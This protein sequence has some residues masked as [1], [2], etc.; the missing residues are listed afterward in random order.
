MTANDELMVAA[1]AGGL[2]VEQVFTSDRQLI[3]DTL[4]RMEYDISL[5]NGNF[6]HLSEQPFFGA[7][8]VLFS[9]LGTVPGHKGVVMYSNSGAAADQDD[10]MFADLAASASASRC[11]VYPVHAVG[12]VAAAPG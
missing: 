5:W 11:S 9:V 3:E 10:L 12:L 7:M 2:R 8:E 6:V 4:E 1:I